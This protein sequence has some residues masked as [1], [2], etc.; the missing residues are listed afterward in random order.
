M[1]HAIQIDAIALFE[2]GL[3][4]ARDNGGQMIDDVRPRRQQP[5]RSTRHREI[6]RGA[7]GGAEETMRGLRRDDIRQRQMTDG[8]ARQ[9]AIRG[10]PLGELAAEHPGRPQ[11]HDMHPRRPLLCRFA[12]TLG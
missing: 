8:R 2:I 5:S 6:D 1:A 4:L 11:D 7:I 12:G 10:D 3:G 9:T